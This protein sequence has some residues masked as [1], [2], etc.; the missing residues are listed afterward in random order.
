MPFLKLRAK[1]VNE[2]A[3]GSQF[4]FAQRPLPLE[5]KAAG[6][7]DDAGLALVGQVRTA[8][9]GAS[10]WTAESLEP[11]VKQIAEDAGLGLGK[12]A[13]PLRAALTGRTTSPGI[14]DVLALLGKEESLGRL[15][16]S[17]NRRNAIAALPQGETHG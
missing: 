1:S 9:A 11:L 15:D 5:E 4:L 6:L 2:L 16:D 17:V 13:Q 3:D 14:F 8:I 12:V 7:L 10:D